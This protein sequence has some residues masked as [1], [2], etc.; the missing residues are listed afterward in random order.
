MIFKICILA[1]AAA[2]IAVSFKA[3]NENVSVFLIVAV[4]VVMCAFVLSEVM[5]TF[6]DVASIFTYTGADS[7]YLKILL[8]CLGITLLTQ[9]AS[10]ICE[11]ASYKA[12]S[13]QI[14]FAGKVAVIALSMPIFKNVLQVSMGLIKQ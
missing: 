2:I 12:L 3:Q 10:D 9:M 7:A 13:S 1:V 8:K 5:S 6:E 14:I 11:D 4:S